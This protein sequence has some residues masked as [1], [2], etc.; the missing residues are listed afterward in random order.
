MEKSYSINSTSTEQFY[1]QYLTV[2]R[3]LLPVKLQDK[4]LL[5]LAKLLE[6]N[7]Q[8]RDMPPNK[9]KILVF[10]YDNVTKMVD[11]LGISRDHFNNLLTTLRKKD[12]LKN[13][14]IK[15]SIIVSSDEE[16]AITY[17]LKKDEG[18]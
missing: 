3:P 15:D 11:E 12:Y 6:N 5:V 13:N 18:Q 16:H 2:I 14:V 1:I 7:D 10:D 9:R 8:Y 4:E 17:K